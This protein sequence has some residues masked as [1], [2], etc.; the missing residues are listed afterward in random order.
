MG[1][2][3]VKPVSIRPHGIDCDMTEAVMGFINQNNLRSRFEIAIWSMLRTKLTRQL[4]A[5]GITSVAALVIAA[6][7]LYSSAQ[8]SAEKIA[9]EIAEDSA[10]QSL[11]DSENAARKAIETFVGDQVKE[12]R[13]TSFEVLQQNM[14]QKARLDGLLTDV[15][16]AQKRLQDIERDNTISEVSSVGRQLEQLG[17]AEKLDELIRELNARQDR[18][19][20]IQQGLTQQKEE[21][22]NLKTQDAQMSQK[23]SGALEVLSVGSH[24]CSINKVLGVGGW[25][26]ACEKK[27][28]FSKPVSV[29][30]EV[31]PSIIALDFPKNNSAPIYQIRIE[32]KTS[33]GFTVVAKTAYHHI[34][35]ISFSWIAVK[36]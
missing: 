26:T 8:S 4:G 30:Y 31:A 25:E 12:V 16:E 21:I 13:E 5:I 29:A 11:T 1:I 17:G 9:R 19:S 22:A 32:D 18:L 6:W 34:N 2:L 3:Q 33:T 23:V 27:V 15:T 35:H 7:S 14:T 10:R 36:K 20:E 24:G 28:I